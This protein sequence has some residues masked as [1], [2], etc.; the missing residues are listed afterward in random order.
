MKHSDLI[1]LATDYLNAEREPGKTSYVYR[2]D[3]TRHRY[4]VSKTAVLMLGRMLSEAVTSSD[5]NDTYSVWCSLTF[6][7]DLG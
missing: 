1:Q 7:E 3:G 2:D 6:S 5:A 4:R